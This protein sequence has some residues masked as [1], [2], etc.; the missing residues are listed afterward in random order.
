MPWHGLLL[1]E[2][3][4]YESQG[5]GVRP[6]DLL[7]YARLRLLGLERRYRE[8]RTQGSCRDLDEASLNPIH[9]RAA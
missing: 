8:Q 6:I 3:M 9:P 4:R 1:A 2:N 5:K 7:D